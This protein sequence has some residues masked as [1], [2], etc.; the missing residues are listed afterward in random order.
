MSLDRLAASGQPVHWEPLDPPDNSDL[1][2]N[3]LQARKGQPVLSDRREPL[4]DLLDQQGRKGLRDRLADQPDPPDKSVRR[5]RR[6][7]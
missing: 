3:R 5:D 6:A 4:A 1:L 7:S 2:D